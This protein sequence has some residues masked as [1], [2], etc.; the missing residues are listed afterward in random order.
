[1]AYE[2]RHLQDHEQRYHVHEKEIFTSVHFL[3]VWSHYLLGNLF[4]AKTDNV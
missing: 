1:V 3:Q 2:R 4:I